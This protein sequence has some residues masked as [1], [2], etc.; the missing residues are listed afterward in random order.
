MA[1]TNCIRILIADDHTVVR[2]GLRTL[3]T[4]KPGMEVVGEAADGVEAVSKARSLK[5]GVI[6]LDMV[7]PRKDGLE[8]IRDIKKDNPNA[9]ILV[10]TVLTTTK[11]S[12][13]PSR[14][15]HWV[16]C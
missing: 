13:R 6:L 1:D 3:I 15:G 7:M 16:T 14:P 11:E 2:E 8:A 5:P 12:F 10:L 9:R 4:A